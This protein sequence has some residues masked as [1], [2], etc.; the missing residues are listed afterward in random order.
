FDSSGAIDWR[1]LDRIV[2]FCIDAGAQALML[3]AGDSHYFCLS[4]EEIAGATRAVCAR[5]AGKVVVIAADRNHAT[6][7]AVEFAR[8]AREA[9]AGIVM[10]L[11]PDWGASCTEQ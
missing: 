7:R 3:T 2:D 10:T 4:D 9:G 1:S 8:F 5:A 6:A 11:P